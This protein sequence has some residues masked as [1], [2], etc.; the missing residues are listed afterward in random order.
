MADQLHGVERFRPAPWLPGRHLQTIVPSLWPAA[1]VGGSAE[2]RVVPVADS[3]AVQLIVNRP[4]GRSRG[5]LLLLHGMG[6]SAESGYVRRTAAPALRRGWTVVRMNMR[7]CGGTQALSRTFYNA[8]QSDDV[9]RVLEELDRARFPLPLALVGFSLGGNLVLRYA[10]LEGA[11]CRAD[12]VAALNPPIDLA[13]CADALERPANRIYQAYYTRKLLGE[14][15]AILAVRALPGFP[16][17]DRSVRSVRRFDQLYT[18]PDAGFGSADEYYAWA[19]AGP[20]LSGLARPATMIS[21]DDDP[22]VP[23][24]SFRPHHG[25]EGVRFLHPARGGHCGYWRSSRPRFWAGE[26]ILGCLETDV[27][28]TPGRG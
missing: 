3:S 26:A 5:T 14:L 6:G 11:A 10:G 20:C 16:P 9:G 8:G 24:E 13:R 4:R 17:P 15:R 22:F 7:N 25:L 12:A 18:A 23:V 28:R 21:A 27:A 1:P 19:S 2:R